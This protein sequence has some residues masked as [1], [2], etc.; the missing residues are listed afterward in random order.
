MISVRFV[1]EGRFSIEEVPIPKVERPDDVLI[2]VEA[3]SICGTDLQILKVPPGHPANDNLILGHEYTGRVVE[4][5]QGVK[6]VS[7]GDR[8][9]IDPNI[10]CERCSY[11]KGGMPNM[12]E[13]MTTLGIFIDGGFANYNVAPDKALHKIS[14]DL[15]PERAVFAEPLSCVLNGINKLKPQP[16]ESALILGAGSI[17]LLFT[18][19]FK[20]SGVKPIVVSEPVKSRRECAE[21]VGADLTVDPT[22]QGLGDLSREAT[23]LGFDIVTDAV[24]SLFDQAMEVARNGGRILLFGQDKRAKPQISPYYITRREITVLGAFIALF[25]FPQAVK[26]LGKGM[27]DLEALTTDIIRLEEFDKGIEKMRSGEAIKI[28]IK[29]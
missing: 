16:G 28:I 4:V 5:G 7:N 1:G 20:A 6:S 25:T 24:G 9:V 10:T 15:P 21:K 3:A 26:I 27:L 11:C 29:P 2:E 17:G 19:L 18:Q 8:V 14:S 22:V 12:C 13:N 23:E